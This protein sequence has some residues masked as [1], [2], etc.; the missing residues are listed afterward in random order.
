M[1]VDLVVYHYFKAFR[2]RLRVKSI[3]DI[4]RTLKKH[5]AVEI[6]AFN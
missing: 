5:L 4:P 6:K 2:Q 1:L 3:L